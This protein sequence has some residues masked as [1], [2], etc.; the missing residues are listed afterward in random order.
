MIFP[1]ALLWNFPVI[2]LACLLVGCAASEPSQTPDLCQD[3]RIVAEI[4]ARK[5]G[6]CIAQEKRL[7]RSAAGEQEIQL[8]LVPVRTSASGDVVIVYADTF[9]RFANGELSNWGNLAFGDSIVRYLDKALDIQSGPVV[10]YRPPSAIYSDYFMHEAGILCVVYQLKHPFEGVVRICGGRQSGTASYA[11]GALSWRQ[12]K[13]RALALYRVDAGADARYDPDDL[14]VMVAFKRDDDG[15]AY[16]LADVRGRRFQGRHPEL[17]IVVPR[18][19]FYSYRV[20]VMGGAT[21]SLGVREGGVL[22]H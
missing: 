17:G 20:D 4:Q 5:M 14:L 21:T 18:F 22:G 11:P 9:V 12:A 6:K 8:A 19:W 7:Y 2:F 3:P 16:Y 15:T 13:E 1:R 10:W